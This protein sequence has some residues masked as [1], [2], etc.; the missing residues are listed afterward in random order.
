MYLNNTYGYIYVYVLI[1][2]L[3]DAFSKAVTQAN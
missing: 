3:F 2:C 1:H